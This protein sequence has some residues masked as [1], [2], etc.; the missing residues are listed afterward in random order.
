MKLENIIEN[1]HKLSASPQVLPKLQKMLLND[2]VGVDDIGALIKMD[3][4]LT[5]EVIRLGNCASFGGPNPCL[6][7]EEAIG[8]IGYEEVYKVVCL[9]AAMMLLEDGAP[10]YNLN[11]GDLWDQSIACAAAMETVMIVLDGTD[12]ASHNAGYTIGLLHGLGKVVI[13]KYCL[14]NGIDFYGNDE[15][16]LILPK[17]E[18]CLLGFDHGEAGA[19]L[20]RKWNFPDSFYIPV[21]YQFA[22]LQAPSQKK[23]SCLLHLSLWAAHKIIDQTDLSACRFDGGATV[24]EKAGMAEEE[25]IKSIAKAKT[26]LWEIRDLFTLV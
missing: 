4:N 1:V 18:K 20:M 19:A 16:D 22:P 26:R 17:W 12:T 24:L 23:L 11:A 3:A 25:L 2:S 8:R 13:N 15:S 14:E 5:A 7:L 9:A 10:V 21:Q 6:S